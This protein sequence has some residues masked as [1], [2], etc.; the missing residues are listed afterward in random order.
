MQY[1]DKVIKG[2]MEDSACY[3]DMG[4]DHA[5][6]YFKRSMMIHTHPRHPRPACRDWKALQPQGRLFSQNLPWS[7][8]C[9]TRT[10]SRTN[11]CTI[12]GN[13]RRDPA[14]GRRRFRNV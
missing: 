8:R 7:H 6:D 4:N 13:D 9:T 2:C 12:V 11:R 10:V 5:L 3:E 14:T 1:T